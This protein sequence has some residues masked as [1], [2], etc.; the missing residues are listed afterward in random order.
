MQS[1]WC[2]VL[3]GPDNTGPDNKGFVSQHLSG[4]ACHESAG[5]LVV[6]GI[7]CDCC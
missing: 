3:S 2:W 5:V 1:V 7:E 4:L 6:W